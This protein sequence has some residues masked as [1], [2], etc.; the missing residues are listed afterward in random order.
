MLVKYKFTH[1]AT[2]IC[3]EDYDKK[4]LLIKV[5]RFI[6]NKF[7]SRLQKYRWNK[8]NKRDDVFLSD[9]RSDFSDNVFNYIKFDLLHLHWVNL[10]FLDFNF[11]KKVKQPIFW[12]L[13]DCW[14]FTGICHYFLKCENYKTSCNKCH[15][16]N[17]PDKTDLS[18]II[19][20][21]KS[22]I[23]SNL[24]LN[25]I[26]P[27]KWL[28]ESASKSSLFKKFKISVIPNTIDLSLYVK[29]DKKISTQHLLLTNSKF[30]IAFGAV[31]STTDY[32]KG[33]KFLV[34]SVLSIKD[35]LIRED[36]SLIIFGSKSFDS[37]IF[38]DLKVLNIGFVNSEEIM[39]DI[40]NSSSVFLLPSLSENFSN[41]ILES[42]A[43][44]T[45]V[46][47]F[48]VGG[49][50][51]IIDHKINGYLARENDFNDFGKG[52]KWCFENSER[53]SFSA[54]IRIADN[55]SFQKIAE[56]HDKMYKSL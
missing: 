53:I 15:Y 29:K 30:Y 6:K 48:N 21:K 19:W 8:Y 16:L 50:S 14:A 46:V 33:F 23:Y 51:D 49:N 31:N 27:S 54:R 26:T 1:D 2:V 7:K 28:A 47:A 35:Y 56:L 44:G 4:S 10:E 20:K 9:L 45:P 11:L 41:S 5:S 39:V 3:I 42:M 36:I 55:Y 18:S 32:V 40:Y 24:N 52:I 43:C 12:T 17:S 13:H 34:S 25:I 38:V 37:K 22:K